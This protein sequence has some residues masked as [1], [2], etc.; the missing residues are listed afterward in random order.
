MTDE[1]RDALLLLHG[2]MIEFLA[3]TA[4]ESMSD[5]ISRNIL[6]SLREDHRTLLA[7][8]RHEIERPEDRG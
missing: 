8:A 2:Q 7:R 5:R 3:A 1:T 4:L 6:V